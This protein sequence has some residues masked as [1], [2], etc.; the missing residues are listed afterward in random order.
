MPGGANSG[1]HCG[2]TSSAL[3]V[4]PGY[5]LRGWNPV[6]LPFRTKKP[7]DQ[8]WQD[9]TITAEDVDQFFNSKPMN[10]GVILG[11]TSHGLTDVD[12]DCDEA[13]AIAPALLPPTKA[14]FGRASARGSH[15]LY[16]HP[17][18][19]ATVGKA[20]EQFKDP[21]T[22]GMLLEVRV[23]GY[24]GAQSVF[25][26]STHETGEIIAWEESGEP[27]P[28]GDDLVQRAKITAALCLLARYWPKV[29]PGG[30]GSRHDAALTL[31]GFLARGGFKPAMVKLCAEFVARAANDEEVRDRIRAAEDA[32]I[33]YQ[34]G[35]KTR[36]YPALKEMFGDKVPKRLTFPGR[37]SWHPPNPQPT[38]V[39]GSIFCHL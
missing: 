3:D 26:G 35:E 28:V 27:A 12:L 4:A 24:T 33:A 25:P 32:T 15:R 1:N 22:R 6:P 2:E 30:H 21:I 5:A 9:R 16:Y 18:L 19:A 23:G 11:P 8:G 31:G 34:K 17:T 20:T 39:A 38:M 37:K 29:T 36:G 14:I 13:I 10:I 7:I